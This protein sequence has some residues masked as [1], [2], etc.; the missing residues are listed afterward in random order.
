M[1]M[2]DTLCVYR[3]VMLIR[4][5]WCMYGE[6]RKIAEKRFKG[7]EL[8]LGR[9]SQLKS[10]YTKVIDEYLQLNHMRKV[11]E[12]EKGNKNAVYLPHHAVV[13]EDRDT[14]KVRVVFDASCKGTNGRSL[15]DNLM[16][17]PTLQAE[18]R[19]TIMCWRK[20]KICLVADIIKMYR[21]VL[22]NRK[23]TPYQR[24]LWRENPDKPIEDFE[25]MTVT[26]GT[27]SGPYLAV[28]ALQQLAYEECQSGSEISQ[29]ILEDFYMD[30][31][32]TGGE[33]L[34]K[35]FTIY[36]ELTR[37]LEK[38]GFQLQ[39]WRSNSKELL[40]KI[41]G[42]NDDK[43]E[44]LRIKVD[45][46]N[47][48]LGLTWNSQ[49]D[50]FQYT[51]DL[52]PP[53]EPATKRNII[54]DISRLF[55]PLGWLAPCIIVAK[56][57]I[58]KLWLAGV[59]WDQEVPNNL[60]KEWTTYRQNLPALAGIKIPRWLHSYECTKAELHGFADASKL[61]YA[62]VVYLRSFDEMGNVRVSL[63]TSKTK[64]APIKKVS[65]PRLELCAAVL[66]SK[67]M[68][69]VS[70]VL[71][72]SK[73]NLHAYTDSEVVLAWLNQ[74]PSRWKTFVANRVSEI[75]IT[76]DTQYWSHVPSKENP[77]DCASRGISPAELAT[78]SMWIDGPE[79]L[80]K[81]VINFKRPKHLITSLEQTK[82][83][84]TVLDTNFW[85]VFSSLSK[86]VRVVAYCCRFLN[87]RK[88]CISKHST[89][90]LTK[91]EI[92]EAM[93][94]CIKRCQEEELAE[95]LEELK[96]KGCLAK[97]KSLK[98]L[99]LF[100]D[101]KGII[102]IGGRLEM[103]QLEFNEKHPILIPKESALTKLLI[104]DAHK[105][106]MHGGPQLMMTYLRSMYWIM[107]V[108]ALVKK[109]CRDCV[110]CIRYSSKATT[111][112]MGQLPSS[113]VTPN[114]PF[115]ISG[116]DY[117]GPIN[118]RVS[119]GRG[120]KSYKGYIALFVC[121]STRAIHLEAVSDLTTQGFLAAFRRFVAR[122]GRCAELN[123]DNATN[124]VG[125]ARELHCLFNEEK[126]SFKNELA[127]SLA[128]NGTHWNFIPP[129]SPNFGGL[130]EA[131]IKS[132]KFHLKRVIGNST[133]TYEE[134][135]TVLTQIEA[136]L[137]SRP[138]SYVEGQN[139]LVVLTPGH[140]LV[141]DAL[142][143]VPDGNYEKSNT[144]TLRRWQLHQKMM[145]DFWRG[146]SRDYL[147]QLLQRHKWEYQNPEPSIGDVV[148]IKED[149][150]PPGRWLLGKIE[151][152]HPGPDKITRVV[153][154]R[155][156]GTV[157]KRPTSKICI[158]PVTK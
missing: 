63:V 85:Q 154:V 27:A 82:V 89:I 155:T 121:M 19:H 47:K 153:S 148:L 146:W 157:I 81:K 105:K 22:V 132:T 7:L 69:E 111:Q 86:L 93:E 18:L 1:T 90:Y 127:E 114:K 45:D 53:K 139:E 20:Y 11:N 70:E 6:S 95:E 43:V 120:N 75:L 94:R 131:G 40:D 96:D 126:S 50:V 2:G 14:T 107:G 108:K 32:M 129:R 29:I 134:L 110:V 103:S 140:F 23:D 133:L 30:D 48:I 145:Q 31:L 97:G 58:Q 137:N 66:L 147:H 122:R 125:A 25:L 106:T 21:Q 143:V 130:W 15:N 42:K 60:L 16:I 56:I 49:E 99:N 12:L 4:T 73:A 79:F 72:I 61:A 65:I 55:D 10:E 77:A 8:K 150:M 101:A 51:V 5:V 9:N 109:Y 64:V 88:S 113:R 80:S 57:L 46:V 91:K 151:Q 118:I 141:G 83:H 44:D 98:S 87:L 67:L 68:T 41:R 100:F 102:R 24:I 74:H 3:F 119:K 71:G 39:K 136:C 62:A 34:E 52:T 149:D 38:G 115:L 76:L 59:E 78:T 135:G 13:R 117:A 112:L 104:A 158:L 54:S 26:F 152:K 33:N 128:N 37:V 142:V 123:S 116:L 144:S 92:D 17:G 84:T 156:K 138:L 124:F 28:R 35:C 36:N